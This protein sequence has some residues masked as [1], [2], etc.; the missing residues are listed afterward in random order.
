MESY[1]TSYKLSCNVQWYHSHHTSHILMSLGVGFLAMVA[2]LGGT[3]RILFLCARRRIR[4]IRIILDFGFLTL[5]I[6]LLIRYIVDL[7]HIR[8]HFCEC[9]PSRIFH[10][11]N[12]YHLIQLDFLSCLNNLVLC[13]V[14]I[15]TNN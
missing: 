3:C 8:I 4:N 11:R 14:R 12:F 6:L 15:A 2:L 1:L 9:L 10:L 5:G 7:L 13:L